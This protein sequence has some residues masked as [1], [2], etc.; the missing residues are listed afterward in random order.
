MER[1]RILWTGDRSAIEAG[2]Q[3]LRVLGPFVALAL[4]LIGMWHVPIAFFCSERAL[5]PGELVMHA[6]TITSWN[7]STDGPPGKHP[8]MG[9]PRSCIRGRT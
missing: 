5:I 9:M 8:P 1:S 6:S 7:I 4:F 2:P 3:W